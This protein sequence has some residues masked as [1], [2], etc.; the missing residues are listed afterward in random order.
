M[1]FLRIF[2]LKNSNNSNLQFERPDGGEKAV[3]VHVNFNHSHNADDT[4]EFI[5]LVKSTGAGI[6]R[7][8]ETS[9]EK[10]DAKYFIGSGKA[11][12]V[13]ACVQ[14]DGA[15]IVLFNHALTPAQQRNLEKLFDCK[16]LDRTGLI[17]DIFAQR[18]RTFEGK[19]QVEL[20]Q[21]KHLSTRLIRGWTHLERQKGGIGLRGPGETQLESDRRMIRVKIKNIM[22]RLEKVR[23]QR[24][25][26]RRSRKKNDIPTVSI[27]GYTNA[28]KS[29]LFNAL[30]ASKVYAANQLFA[31]L[32]TTLRHLKLH[33]L[34]EVVL[35]DTVGF[36]RD[37]PHHLVESFRA[38]LEETRDADLLLH[39]IDAAHPNRNVM[40]E[41]V[42]LVLK[43]IGADHVPQLMI[44]NKIDLLPN[45]H[46]HR[47]GNKIWVSALQKQGLELIEQTIVDQLSQEIIRCELV[48]TPSQGKLRSQLHD[49]GVVISEYMD[50]EGIWNLSVKIQ[51]RDYDR[52][53]H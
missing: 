22:N 6:L 26:S 46:A 33:E 34:G 8:I 39:V 37:L 38:T 27:V 21:L 14:Q 43:E 19:L 25:Q 16:V 44:F 4:N 3:L 28:G 20:A 50:D 10:P 45:I 40:I 7:L 30:T 17:L 2:F 32:D 52:L 15:D 36:I 53:I 18:A 31:T 48:L 42:N 23:T 51:R 12:E 29:S 35:A 13:L 49:L 47:E 41:D 1:K 9:R 5:D 11:Q 24:E